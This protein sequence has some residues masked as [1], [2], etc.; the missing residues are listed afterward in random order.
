MQG[1]R[2]GD[3]EMNELMNERMCT[4]KERKDG[5]SIGLGFTVQVS[6]PG[7]PVELSGSAGPDVLIDRSTKGTSYM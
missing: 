2:N 4:R 1:E 3:R 7:C 6:D 5:T